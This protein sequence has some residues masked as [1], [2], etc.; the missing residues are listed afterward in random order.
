MKKRMLII[1]AILLL[2]SVTNYF[3]IISKSSIRAVEFV[4]ILIMGVLLGALLHQLIALFY[5]PKK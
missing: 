5:I 4:S 2:S 1:T 3:L